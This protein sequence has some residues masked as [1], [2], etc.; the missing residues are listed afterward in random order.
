MIYSDK[1]MLFWSN[2]FGWVGFDSADRFTGADRKLFGLP[3]LGGGLV[4]WVRIK[5]GE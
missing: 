5:E 4:L 1:E 2:D 3:G